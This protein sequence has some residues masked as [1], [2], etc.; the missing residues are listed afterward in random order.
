MKCNGWP[1]RA[2]STTTRLSAAPGLSGTCGEV[3]PTQRLPCVG[4]INNPNNLSIR[5][6]AGLYAKSMPPV[7]ASH[8]LFYS[9]KVGNLAR[10]A[11]GR[12]NVVL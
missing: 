3:L 5:C 8:K 2:L 11:N 4:R 6:I 10:C 1:P 9:N 12:I 7:R